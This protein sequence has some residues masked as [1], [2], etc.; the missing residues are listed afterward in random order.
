MSWNHRIVRRNY[1]GDVMYEIHEVYYD[2]DGKVSGLTQE[3]ISIMEESLEDL[4]KTIERL[5][6]CLEKSIIDYET[7][8]EIL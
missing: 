5:Q 4:K 7:N 8:E 1:S 3:P 6:N 2:K